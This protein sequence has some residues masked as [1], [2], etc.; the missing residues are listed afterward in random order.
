MASYRTTTPS[1]I[2]LY[3]S[4][5]TTGGTLSSIPANAS[6]VVS[7]Y[8][9]DSN[10]FCT[11]Y[12]SQSGFIQKLTSLNLTDVPERDCI[13]NSNASELNMREY[14]ST[15]APLCDKIPKGTAVTVQEHNSEWSSLTYKTHRGFVMTKYLRD[16]DGGITETNRLFYAKNNSSALNLREG[17]G[18]SHG[19]IYQLPKNR[20]VLC[21]AETSNGWYK[22]RYKGQA[23][24]LMKSYMTELT[25]V[26]VHATYVER[27]NYIARQELGRNQAKYY[28]NASGDW[29]QYFVNWLLRASLLPSLRVPT[30]GGT[31][32]GITFWVKNTNN[33]GGAFYFKSAEHKTRINNETS[34]GY[35]LNVGNTLTTAEQNFQPQAGD[36]IYLRWASETAQVNVSHTGFVT[37]VQ[38]TTVY[39]IEG[40]AGSPSQVRACSYSASD[41]RIVGYARPNYVMNTYYDD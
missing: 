29:C 32:W 24:Y 17:P 14:P 21:E 31:G 38:G 7:D 13:I 19:S 33:N 30:S 34:Y 4:A 3:T 12:N 6:I 40:N 18:T 20:I 41:N 35:N 26:P 16:P 36:I 2:I 28:D 11:T 10:W 15:S 39:T 27:C 23:V 5:S 25:D 22:T 1:T 8:C 9:A 37:D